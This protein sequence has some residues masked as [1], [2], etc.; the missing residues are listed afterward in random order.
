MVVV[1]ILVLVL[2]VELEEEDEERE[3]W[4]R[5]GHISVIIASVSEILA[6]TIVQMAFSSTSCPINSEFCCCLVAKLCP[7]LF[8]PY[9]LQPTWILCPWDFPGKNTGVGCHFLLQGVFPTQGSNPPLLHWQ[10]DSFPL[11]DQ[12]SLTLILPVFKMI[13]FYGQWLDLKWDKYSNFSQSFPISRL[14]EESL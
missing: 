14:L 3:G 13:K 11:S 6:W 1:V 12:G 5:E 7:I 2:T 10:A 4:S 9:G 8:R